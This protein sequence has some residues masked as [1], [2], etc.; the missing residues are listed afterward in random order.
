M[1]K[2]DRGFRADSYVI[3]LEIDADQNVVILT[4]ADGKEYRYTV[5]ELQGKGVIE[6]AVKGGASGTVYSQGEKFTL[7][8]YLQLFGEETSPDYLT[9]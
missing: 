8:E 2:G 5:E 9:S 1:P 3:D 7:E 6:N 4:K